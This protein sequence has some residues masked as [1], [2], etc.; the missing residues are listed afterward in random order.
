MVAGPQSL[1]EQEQVST[2]PPRPRHSLVSPNPLKILTEAHPS[3]IMH[4]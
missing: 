4:T 1:M 2:D 3:R